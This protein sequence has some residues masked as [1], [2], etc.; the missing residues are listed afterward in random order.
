MEVVLGRRVGGVALPLDGP[1]CGDSA[2]LRRRRELRRPPRGPSLGAASPR[3]SGRIPPWNLLVASES[4][5][6]RNP[7]HQKSK[8]MVSERESILP[9]QQ[10]SSSVLVESGRSF[11]RM[12]SFE[13]GKEI[14][15]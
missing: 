14:D 4:V 9:T 10:Q 15:S 2:A 5:I 12:R 6:C 13:K 3:V 8:H 11:L 7:L 1:A